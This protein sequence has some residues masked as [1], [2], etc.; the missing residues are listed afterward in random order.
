[1]DQVIAR[2]MRGEDDGVPCVRTPLRF[3]DAE[4]VPPR[5]A[6]RLDQDGER[7]RSGQTD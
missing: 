3:S 5:A 6:P 4:T 2:E 7:L 1:M